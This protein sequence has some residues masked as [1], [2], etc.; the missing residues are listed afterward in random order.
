M[1]D[2]WYDHR[3]KRSCTGSRV[4]PYLDPQTNAHCLF[5]PCSK[6]Q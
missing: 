6:P 2:V 3:M 5:S 1:S 4:T